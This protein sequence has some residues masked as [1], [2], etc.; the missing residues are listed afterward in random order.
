MA[1]GT[2]RTG[3]RAQPLA[4][5][6]AAI[7]GILAAAK[8]IAV[9]GASPN[10]ARPSFGVMR[11]LLSK[12]F[13]VIPVNPGQAGRAI[14]GQPCFADLAGVGEPVDMID[15]FR[16]SDA[17]PGIVEEALALSPRP[18]AI[19]MQLGVRHDEAARRAE[20]EGVTV[21]MDRCPAIEY[22]RLF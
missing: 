14:L 16:A 20:A 13:R 3:S 4:Y 18:A 8:V 6:D 12:G 10:E 9:V 17:V 21:V 19:W 11:F 7:R 1:D 5:P 15:V 2:E 22:A